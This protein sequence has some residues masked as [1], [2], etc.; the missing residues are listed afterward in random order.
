MIQLASNEKCTG[1][2]AC[3]YMCPQQCI[4]MKENNI[5][6]LYPLINS[7][8][9]VE[10]HKC[11]KICPAINIPSYNYPLK[12]YAAWSNDFVERKTSASGGIAAEIYKWGI[13]NGYY[14]AGAVQNSDFS[15]NFKITKDIGVIRQFKNSKYVFSSLS[16]IFPDIPKI[17]KSGKNIILIGLPCQIAALRKIHR[18]TDNLILID[19]VCH[20]LTPYSYLKQHIRHIE[21]KCNK[22]ATKMYFRDPNFDTSKY[23]FSL[24]DENGNCFYS[25][26]TK[27]GDSY[28]YGYHRAISYRE[29]CYHCQYAKS[30]RVSDITL[31]DYAGLG[32]LFPC[33]Y[34]SHKVSAVLVNTLKGQE[35]ISTLVNENR[36]F[37]EERAIIEPLNTNSQLHHHIIKNKARIKFEK[38]I[39]KYDG[40]FNKAMS[41]IVNHGL[42]VEK[43]RRFLSSSKKMLTILSINKNEKSR[44]Y[45]N[46]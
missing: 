26:R 46:S 41:T 14:V 35:L 22:I 7:E 45:Y 17:I 38:R 23:Y 12:A 20:G 3:S 29:N 5:G 34:S 15:V 11:E 16:N 25:K 21:N 39:R 2:G 8:K 6:V 27:N 10:C 9:C 24:Y 13:D 40:D 30:D 33:N 32:K 1:C 4:Q 28:Q 36:I 19:V 31:A 44:Y 43:M 18:N 37:A 42:L